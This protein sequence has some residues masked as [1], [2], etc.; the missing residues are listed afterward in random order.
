MHVFI[1]LLASTA[2]AQVTTSNGPVIG[3]TTSSVENF[4][5]VPFAQ[6]PTGTLRLRPPQSLSPTSTTVIATGTPKAC[7]QFFMQ[8]DESS[9]A[10]SVQTLLN[11]SPYVQNNLS[12]QGEDCLTLN[13]QRPAGTTRLSNYPVVVWIFGGSFEHGAAA[14]LD[15]TTFIQ[16]SVSLNHPV[17]YVAMNYRVAGF[18]FLGGAEIAAN[19]SSNLGLKDQRLALQWVQDNIA[20]FGGDPTRFVSNQTV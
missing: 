12:H 16:K 9:L 15:A 17:I 10:G 3:S 6:Q 5:G 8:I 7:P 1:A 13:V 4:Y 11:G 19:K 2:F 14:Q 18:G 20:A